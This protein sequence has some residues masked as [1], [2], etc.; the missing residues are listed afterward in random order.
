MAY[1]LVLDGAVESFSSRLRLLY[2]KSCGFFITKAELSIA[3]MLVEK[4]AA[5]RGGGDNFKCTKN[6]I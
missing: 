4:A 1:S 3:A 2:P 5:L 6:F